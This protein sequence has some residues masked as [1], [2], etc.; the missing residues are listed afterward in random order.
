MQRSAS[1]RVRKFSVG[2]VR[3]QSAVSEKSVDLRSQAD[4]STVRT[5]LAGAASP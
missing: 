2:S 3:S 5:S 1:V 4:A